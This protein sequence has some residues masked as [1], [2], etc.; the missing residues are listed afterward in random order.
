MVDRVKSIVADLSAE[1]WKQRERA[2]A[3]LLQMGPMVKSV[4]K[5]LSGSVP[6]EAQHRIDSVL[7]EFEKKS[8]PSAQATP[9]PG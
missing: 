9:D 5:Q 7:G 8:Q 2:E 3:Q 4:L 6:P 1:D